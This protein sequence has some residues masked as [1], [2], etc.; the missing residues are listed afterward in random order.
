[1]KNNVQ[2]SLDYLGI[3]NEFQEFFGIL[4]ITDIP[5]FLQYIK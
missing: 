5:R 2:S 4:K 1:M 3:P